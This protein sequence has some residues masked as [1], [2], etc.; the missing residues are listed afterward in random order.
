M[1]WILCLYY[2]DLF[3]DDNEMDHE[4]GPFDAII[5]PLRDLVIYPQM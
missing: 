5:L 4:E 3:V 1:D 2:R